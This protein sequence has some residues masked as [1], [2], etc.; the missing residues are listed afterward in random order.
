M[1]CRVI[2]VRNVEF[3]KDGRQINGKSLYFTYPDR[4]VSGLACDKVFLSERILSDVGW[5]PVVDD[6][7]RPVYNKWGKIFDVELL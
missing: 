6:E 1:S 7:F 4:N 5:T 3:E 2:G